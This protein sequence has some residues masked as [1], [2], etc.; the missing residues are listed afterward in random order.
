M[1]DHTRQSALT[2]LNTLSDS[3]LTLDSIMNDFYQG[4]RTLDKRDLALVNALVYGVIRWR[5]RLDHIIEHF[6]KTPLNKIKPVIM[7]ILRLGVFQ[8][9]MMSR[10]WPRKTAR[11]GSPN[12]STVS[13]ETW[14]A[15]M[16]LCLFRNSM[17]TRP[18]L[19]L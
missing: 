4:N 18:C 7:N 13:Y 10:I 17:K 5:N 1:T 9:T 8:I 12:S 2:L 15:I 16:N 3:H 19:S 6:S 14:R 11:P